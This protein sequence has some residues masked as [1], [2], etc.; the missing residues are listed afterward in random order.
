[1]YVDSI[2]LEEDAFIFK[3]V[4]ATAIGTPCGIGCRFGSHIPNTFEF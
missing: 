2:K 4:D 1:V 3:R